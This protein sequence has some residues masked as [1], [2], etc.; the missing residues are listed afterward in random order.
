MVGT[1]FE[2]FLAALP[3]PILELEAVATSPLGD[4]A[5]RTVCERPGCHVVSGRGA[6]AG[7]PFRVLAELA[8]IPAATRR[9]GV[10]HDGRKAT[11]E[12]ARVATGQRCFPPPFLDSPN[13][14]KNFSLKNFM[15]SGAIASSRHVGKAWKISNKKGRLAKLATEA[16]HVDINP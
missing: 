6:E 15:G 10:Q 9:A 1:L 7:K 12:V 5:D 2:K 11:A 14:P 13:V 4:S 8:I 3:A 16:T